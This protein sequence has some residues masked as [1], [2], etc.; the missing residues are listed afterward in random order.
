MNDMGNSGFRTFDPAKEAGAEP[1]QPR[2]NS[3]RDRIMRGGSGAGGAPRPSPS[4]YV[5]QPQAVASDAHSQPVRETEP[6]QARAAQVDPTA[7]P[8]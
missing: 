8:E 4:G 7:A 1:P 2:G 5:H 3:L 6:E